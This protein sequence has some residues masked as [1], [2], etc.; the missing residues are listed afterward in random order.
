MMRL[1]KG[2]SSFGAIPGVYGA[3]GFI[4]DPL[5]SLQIAE[6]GFADFCCCPNKGVFRILFVNRHK[7]L[8]KHSDRL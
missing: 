8:L 4:Y 3:D 5:Y 1:E 7:K 2:N 6:T